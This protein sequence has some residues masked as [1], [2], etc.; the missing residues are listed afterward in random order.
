MGRERL[1]YARGMYY[2]LLSLKVALNRD[3]ILAVYPSLLCSRDMR[4]ETVPQNIR[5]SAIETVVRETID[6]LA[7]KIG[8]G[9]QHRLSWVIFTLKVFSIQTSILVSLYVIIHAGSFLRDALHT[10][11]LLRSSDLFALGS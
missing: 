7:W 4:C 5:N 1:N 8:V 9:L 3:L 2:L 10:L 6:E 11:S